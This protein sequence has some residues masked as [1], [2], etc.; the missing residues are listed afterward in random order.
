MS[1]AAFLCCGHV[2]TALRHA[3][4]APAGYEHPHSIWEQAA[5]VQAVNMLAV[6]VLSA[7]TSRN[8]Q[9]CFTGSLQILVLLVRAYRSACKRC[10]DL[11]RGKLAWQLSARSSPA[12]SRRTYTAGLSQ[13][14]SHS[15]QHADAPGLHVAL[16]HPLR[17]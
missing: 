7:G 11:A 10:A 1:E 9:V 12:P 15:C 6:K 8:E 13:Q 17:A 4:E 2:M 3:L 16:Q 5:H 14:L